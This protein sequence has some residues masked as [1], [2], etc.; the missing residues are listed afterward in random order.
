M[1]HL[2]PDDDAR[3][4]LA[5]ASWVLRLQHGAEQAAEVLDQEQAK[6]QDEMGA[7]QGAFAEGLEALGQVGGCCRNL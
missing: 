4:R 2:L 3:T 7:A 5:G 6:L 1:C